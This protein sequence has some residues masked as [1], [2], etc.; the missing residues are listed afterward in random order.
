MR[1]Y[2]RGPTMNFFDFNRDNLSDRPI[3][4]EINRLIEAAEPPSVNYRQYLGASAIGSACLRKI[5]FD[6]MCDPIFP[7][8]IKDIFGRGHHF[9]EISRQHLIAAGFQFAPKE[10]LEFTAVDGLV[11]GHCDGIIVAGPLSSLL[12]P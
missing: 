9:E 5:Q 2:S 4:L 12:Y 6:W 1:E 8:R 10:K 3:N 11:R 7:A